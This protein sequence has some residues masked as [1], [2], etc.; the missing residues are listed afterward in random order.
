M[1]HRSKKIHGSQ[2]IRFLECHKHNNIAKLCFKKLKEAKFEVYVLSDEG[3]EIRKDGNGKIMCMVAWYVLR[4]KHT[5]SMLKFA[6][7]FLY[8]VSIYFLEYK[9]I[10]YMLDCL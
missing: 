9:V 4:R 3:F 8:F 10:I 5:I 2:W 6:I 1:G 7:L